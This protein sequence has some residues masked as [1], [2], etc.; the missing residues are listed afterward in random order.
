MKS[1]KPASYRP[2]SAFRREAASAIKGRWF[3]SMLITLLVSLLSLLPLIAAIFAITYI[4]MPAS[5]AIPASD[6]ASLEAFLSSFLMLFLLIGAAALLTFLISPI[7]LVSMNKLSVRLLNDEKPSLRAVFPSFREWGKSLR[8]Q[9]LGAIYA[10]WPVFAGY[11]LFAVGFSLL[12]PRLSPTTELMA[13]ISSL[14]MIA[15]L[16]LMVYSITRQIS[17]APAQ[18]LLVLFPEDNARKL[19]K[20]SRRSMRGYKGRLFLLALS[21]IGWML[22]SVLVPSL[23]R[24]LPDG[25]L[26]E[27]LLLLIDTALTLLCTLPLSVYINTS[28]AAFV[29][30]LPC[31]R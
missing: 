1:S 18:Y 7:P 28:T 2:L 13:G 11:A 31:D 22:L 21:F 17:Y 4:P 14:A 9:I 5:A 10:M 29:M 30:H 3:K 16:A 12:I 27:N 24:F 15:F 20:T 26:H 23:V 6:P 19:L 8:V 25:L